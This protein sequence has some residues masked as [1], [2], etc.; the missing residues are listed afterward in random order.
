M[1]LKNAWREIRLKRGLTQAQLAAKIGRTKDMVSKIE[2][3]KKA[4]TT[5][6]IARACVALGC[7]V[8]DLYPGLEE[9]TA[10]N[11]A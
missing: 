5:D 11:S 2:T 6:V 3:G 9:E 7:A 4:T 10:T 1:R 8:D